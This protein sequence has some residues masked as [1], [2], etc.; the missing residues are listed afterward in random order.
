MKPLETVAVIGNGIIGHGIAQVFAAAGKKVAMIGRDEASLARALGKIAASLGDFAGHDLI[1][2]S[3]VAE[4][5]GRIRTS[6]RLEDA[7]GAELVIEAVTE[8]LALKRGIFGKLDRICPPSAVLASSSGQPAS[9]LIDEVA[10][11]ER[12]IATHFWYPP[13]LIPLVEVCAGPKTLIDVT[14]W[15]CEELRA[16]GKEPAV[17]D[18]EIPG[19]IGNRLQFAML[20]E[21]WAL[22]ASGAASAEAID[23]VVRNSFG[24]RVGITGPIESADAGGLYTMY[25]FG[26]SLMPD[27]DARPEPDPAIAKLVEAGANGIANGKGVYDWSQRDGQALLAARMEELFRWLKADKARKR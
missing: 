5:L 12:V 9:A 15:V 25:H 17:I 4:S 18:Q 23:I 7:G 10:H 20:R 6:T 19:F 2:R 21:A 14:M 16:A 13:Q 1:E 24:R 3:A 26:K 11:P 27:L 8:D 22:W